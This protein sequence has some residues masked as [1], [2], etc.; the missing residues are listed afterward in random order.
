LNVF[1]N[2]EEFLNISVTS[3]GAF[4]PLLFTNLK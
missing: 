3:F 2:A 4:P 1:L